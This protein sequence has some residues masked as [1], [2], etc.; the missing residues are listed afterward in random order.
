MRLS[1]MYL[2]I[3]PSGA[4]CSLDRVI[5]LW[6]GRISSAQVMVSM[7][8]QRLIS[9]NLALLYITTVWLKWGGNTWQDGTATYYPA[10]LAEFFRFPEPSAINDFPMVYYT[11]YGTLFIEFALGTLVFFK[12]LRRYVLLSGVLLH[13]HIEYSMNIPLFS[14]LMVTTYLCFYDGDE[15]SA[16]AS[17]VGSRLQKFKVNVCLPSGLQLKPSAIG[18]LGAID[19][20]QLVS[21]ASGTSPNWTATD[22]EKKP[23]SVG[24]ALKTRG[25]GLWVVGWVPGVWDR[26]LM[27]A[28][29]PSLQS[30][31]GL[32]QT[33][34][35]SPE[36]Q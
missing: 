8:P 12:P 15:V 3:A 18:F 11:T 30:E 24:K 2:A 33:E 32:Q 31:V 20:F 35:T 36:R 16:W 17:R 5:A 25:V 19:P 27:S 6:K 7:W 4:A 28:T 22:F 34:D 21:F 14:Y 13:A 26:I 29:E 1:A 23:L 10:R 9:A